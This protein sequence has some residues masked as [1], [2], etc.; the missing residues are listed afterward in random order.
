MGYGTPTINQ[1]IQP[2]IDGRITER[3]LFDSLFPMWG[4]I[5]TPSIVA[6]A[7]AEKSKVVPMRQAAE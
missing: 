5:I 6:Q 3:Q 1:R 7:T 4:P 2:F